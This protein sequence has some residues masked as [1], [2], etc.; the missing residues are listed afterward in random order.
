MI[1]SIQLRGISLTP[2]DRMTKDGGCSESLNVRLDHEELAP[3][4]PPVDIT[5]SEGLP[6]EEVYD[7]LFRHKTVYYTN[8]ICSR[9]V[10]TWAKPDLA[11]TIYENAVVCYEE[12]ILGIFY[13]AQYT[14]IR[15]GR[16]DNWPQYIFAP[17]KDPSKVLVYRVV[18]NQGGDNSSAEFA[19]VQSGTLDRVKT[20]TG[21]LDIMY[22][23]DDEWVVI[24]QIPAED[25]YR[26][27]IALGNTI[28]I[29]TELNT[30]WAVF[31][32]GEYKILGGN[33][34]FPHFHF[35]N[36]EIEG[37]K[38]GTSSRTSNEV[39]DYLA[40]YPE[41]V[42]KVSLSSVST[43]SNTSLAISESDLAKAYET[44]RDVVDIEASKKFGK[45][46]V[47]VDYAT[48]QILKDITDVI[49][50]ALATNRR[51]GYYN[52]QMQVVLAIKLADGSRLM[53]PPVLLAPGFEFPYKIDYSVLAYS[54]VDS[55]KSLAHNGPFISTITFKSLYKIFLQIDE[56]ESFFDGWE[57]I[58]EAI[59]VYAT[60]RLIYDSYA[61]LRGRIINGS[62]TYEDYY[63]GKKFRQE[64]SL[65]LGSRNY[66]YKD[67]LLSST[68][69]RLLHT[70]E[71]SE[72]ASLVGGLEVDPGDAIDEDILLAGRDR[73]DT[74]SDMR[75]YNIAYDNASLYNNR[76]IASGIS[77]IM[78]AKLSCLTAVHY[79]N[80]TVPEGTVALP[81][82]YDKT[83]KFYIRVNYHFRD[84]AGDESVLG[85]TLPVTIE[86]GKYLRYGPGISVA[87]ETA[88]TS[89]FEYIVVPDTSCYEIELGL[90][91][92]TGKGI[93]DVTSVRLPLT[94]HPRLN[95]AYYYGGVARNLIDRI[96]RAD[97]EFAE[98]PKTLH[99]DLPNKLYISAP[100]SPFIFP[101]SSRFTFSGSVIGAAIA[102][103]P[104]STGQFGD[105]PIYVFT[106]E[107]MWM[108][109]CND[110]GDI[111]TQKPLN[112]LVAVNALLITPLDNSVL[113]YTDGGMKII[114]GSEV[115]NISEAMRGR[116]WLPGQP[117]IDR[118]SQIPGYSPL[119]E[120][121]TDTISFHDYML[122]A[123]GCAYDY[124][125]RRLIF[126]N[127]DRHYQYIYALDT[128]TWHKTV[129]R[130]EERPLAIVRSLNVY[131]QCYIV[132]KDDN[133]YPV[134]EDWS[135][136]LDESY[137]GT[138]LPCVVMTRS[139]CLDNPDI[140]KSIR[141]VRIRGILPGR[142]KENKPK[143]L[144]LA[145]QDGAQFT[146]LSSL[147]GRAFKY[148]KVIVIADLH[149]GDRISY[150]DID[151]ET[152]RTNKMR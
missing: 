6:T 152:R 19:C 129:Y 123:Q 48:S 139:L 9:E 93:R 37:K 151:F 100:D 25:T 49:S 77:E 79:D 137:E 130:D 118:L 55:N 3:S 149:P 16:A 72:F 27:T 20:P 99:T 94:E 13:D 52:N 73:L 80:G 61:K 138:A 66:S 84:N 78:Q 133:G 136:S 38:L 8:Y 31:K 119:I 4:I 124:S 116:K 18:F 45:I 114:N 63:V 35:A 70:Y 146:P 135:T 103:K 142:T 11:G 127:T 143:Y 144:L 65:E 67:D 141:D 89:I 23:K 2:S 33:V 115:L 51:L 1:K 91:I 59:E 122:G 10:T 106:S 112:R 56:S 145:S 76:V 28:G 50:A 95:C 101:L 17:A 109:Q 14:Y 68:D 32:N 113:F 125:G 131:P 74:T 96:I 98:T 97:G 148:Y 71:L 46:V 132:R 12:D 134:L 108:L 88:Y 140:L 26:K 121:A 7:I 34:P 75:H 44:D 147:H 39:I 81:A 15:I 102:T 53:S 111:M 110:A 54:Y 69:F 62:E 5:A 117:V 150:I 90:S 86:D 21:A 128:D 92:D 24:M 64:G 107:G 60:P 43:Q 83:A 30:T 41:P 85:C 47:T 58:V 82:E 87:G 40:N 120:A 57:D 126:I 42:R 105:F 104:I 22:R 29:V 36:K